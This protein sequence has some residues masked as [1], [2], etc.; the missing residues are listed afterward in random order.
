MCCF[1]FDCGVWTVTGNEHCLIGLWW[2]ALFTSSTRQLPQ[3]NDGARLSAVVPSKIFLFCFS[4]IVFYPFVMLWALLRLFVIAPV[5]E[6]ITIV[7]SVGHGRCSATR[8][9][10]RRC[11]EA[12]VHDFSWRPIRPW[13]VCCYCF[14]GTF[15]CGRGT[16]A[17][18]PT[19]NV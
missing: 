17:L 15:C 2:F 9:L 3:Q 13:C 16:K 7:L 8:C 6:M 18:N 4:L 11:I 12:Q 10:G 5:T 1:H 14:L 19:L